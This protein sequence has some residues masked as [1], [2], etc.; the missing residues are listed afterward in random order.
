MPCEGL[1]W[2]VTERFS[3]R[4]GCGQRQEASHERPLEVSCHL[5]RVAIKLSERAMAAIFD[6][7]A[8]ADAEVC[9]RRLREAESGLGVGGG[10]GGGRTSHLLRHP[11]TPAAGVGGSHKLLVRLHL[12]DLETD[13]ANHW[14]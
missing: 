12:P 4:R 2:R 1:C 11:V 5:A 8:M 7:F 6:S 14:R 10:G 13:R 9:E 3:S